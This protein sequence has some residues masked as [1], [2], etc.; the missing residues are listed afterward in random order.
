M[1]KSFIERCWLF[2]S[3][4]STAYAR[5]QYIA[6]KFPVCLPGH[7]YWY[8]LQLWKV[9]ERGLTIYTTAAPKPQGSLLLSTTLLL[10][11]SRFSMTFP[12]LNPAPRILHFSKILL[13]L[14]VCTTYSRISQQ[15]RPS[16]PDPM[17]SRMPPLKFLEHQSPPNSCASQTMIKL[18][19]P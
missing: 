15:A 18:H 9:S 3:L 19:G 5:P 12:Y 7:Q 1:Q 11:S 2:L 16:L 6:C 8:S 17:V 14:R 10:H 13:S 4:L